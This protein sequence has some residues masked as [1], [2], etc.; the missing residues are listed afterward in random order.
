M[1]LHY[2][3]AAILGLP[4]YSLA[5]VLHPACTVPFS[6]Q[7]PSRRIA[8]VHARTIC[9]GASEGELAEGGQLVGVRGVFELGRTKGVP[10]NYAQ[11]WLDDRGRFRCLMR[12][13][14][15]D[16][17]SAF[18]R[19][20]RHNA[21]RICLGVSHRESAR[22]LF[23]HLPRPTPHI[24]LIMNINVLYLGM[25]SGVKTRSKRIHALETCFQINRQE[26]ALTPFNLR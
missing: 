2:C 16:A 15:S 21:V 12:G 19:V 8:P 25:S 4:R 14:R 13:R 22:L 24:L 20:W 11:R 9:E 7:P 5:L 17:L 6:P 10:V 26:Y 1:L 23:I 3:R 18:W